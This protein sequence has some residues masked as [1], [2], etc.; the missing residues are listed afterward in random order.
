M[1]P[2][3][4]AAISSVQE[5]IS[6]MTRPDGWSKAK[7]ATL[8]GRRDWSPAAISVQER[9][10]LPDGW[11][12]AEDA[13][14]GGRGDWSPAATISV[15]EKITRPDGWSMAKDA[16]LGSRGCP[17]LLPRGHLH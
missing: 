3:P 16:M 5:K 7:D 4:P 14:L 1:Y 9:M 2:C 13:T 17:Y 11:A 12:M 6:S 10:T 15:Q 8:G